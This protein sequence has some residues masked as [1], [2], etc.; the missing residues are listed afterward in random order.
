MTKTFV[1]T[2]RTWPGPGEWRCVVIDGQRT[3]RLGCPGCHYG[4][5]LDHEIDAKGRVSPSVA[6]PN[7]SYHESGVVLEGWVP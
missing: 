5:V 3:A 6:C 4:A 7:C 1:R 2:D